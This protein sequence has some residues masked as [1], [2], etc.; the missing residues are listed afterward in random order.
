MSL[1]AGSRLG[2]YEIVSPLGAGGMGEVF[3]ALDTRLD[4]TVAI[5]ILPREFAANAQWKARFEREARA[6]SQLNHPNICT[7]HDVGSEGGVEYLVMELLEGESLADRLGRGALPIADVLRY[8]VQ[9]AEGLDKA[10][11]SGITHRD[12]KPGNIMITKSGAKLLDFGLAKSQSSASGR[13]SSVLETEHKPLTEEGTIL[14]TFQYMAPEQLEGVEADAR[15]DIFALGCVLYETATGKRAFEGKTRTS[16][17]AAIVAANPRPISEIQPLTPPAFEHVVQ[18]CLEK[19]PDDRWQSA[20]DVAEQ[21]RW[22]GATPGVGR[23]TRGVRPFW[24][25]A[26]GVLLL[27]TIA[28]VVLLLR[29]DREGAA[30]PLYSSVLAPPGAAFVFDSAPMAMSP[31]GHAIAFV[32]RKGA[33]KPM[34]W[35]HDLTSNLAKALP[36]TEEA[37]FPFWSPDSRFLAFFSHGKLRTIDVATGSVETLTDAGSGWT[38]GSWS[39]EGTILFVPAR[40]GDMYGVQVGSAEAPRRIGANG[41]L[42]PRYPVFLPDSRHFLFSSLATMS[43]DPRSGIYLGSLDSPATTFLFRSTSTALY[44][45][46]GWILNWDA[47]R[48]RAIGFDPAK[49]RLTGQAF[50]VADNVQ[51]N[52][53]SGAG[54]YSVSTTGNLVFRGGTTTFNSRLIWFSRDGH[55]LGNVGADA[56]YYGPS[57]SPDGERVAVDI[58]DDE[59]NGDIWVVEAKRR[60]ASRFTMHPAD[61]SAPVWSADGFIYFFRHLGSAAAGGTDI[62]RKKD[63]GIASDELV[64]H[65]P[66]L[67]WPSDISLDGRLLLLGFSR[68]PESVFAGGRQSDIYLFS[69]DSRKAVPYL[70]TSFDES[71]ARFS[72]DQRFVAYSSNETGQPEV[73]V[74]PIDPAGG[75]W[76]VSEGG[77]TMPVWNRTGNEILYISLN[78]ELMSVAIH[79]RPGFGA[80]A[81]QPLFQTAIKDGLGVTYAV[82]ADGKRFLVNTLVE[83]A[84]AS[85]VTLLQNWRAKAPRK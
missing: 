31:D 33:E 60:V 1:T 43:G 80:S 74:R 54:H 22:L 73:F 56:N 7:L 32:V 25:L 40:A 27:M 63:T 14:G 34:L 48:L 28:L 10:H 2:P 41:S 5:K 72:P 78:H 58:S 69:L 42:H 83:D 75:K 57:L 55:E 51:F 68:P 9:I 62:R 61:E 30:T 19:D 36:A 8:G 59:N 52:P 67:M 3:R 79:T 64:Y 85:S 13:Q 77:G 45:P 50:T 65:S 21:L 70:T 23:P 38:G 49:L 24:A 26:A 44:A 71:Q 84:N 82:S 18:K 17:I 47:G 66:E 35:V 39:R 20:H 76:Q 81:P 11:R 53:N 6:I 37:A 46:P 29:R 15:T 12:L 16:L 4:R